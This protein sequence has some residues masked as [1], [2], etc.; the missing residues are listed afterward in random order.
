MS[1]SSLW[2]MNKEYHGFKSKEYRNSWWFSPI[3][4]N[5]LLDKYM[6]DEI[7][8]PYGY[9]KSLIGDFGGQLEGKLNDIINNSENFSDRICWEMSNQQVFFSKDKK[10]I[11]QA[12]IDF[13]NNN[14]N[15]HISK[16]KGISVLR[17]E[18]VVER[19]NKIAHDILDIDENKYPFFVFKNT[20]VDDNVEYWFSKYDERDDK[21]TD[22]SLN[23]LDKYI[24]EFVVIE[25]E[26]IKEFISNLDYFKK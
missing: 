4:W 16:D 5:V 7:Q 26:S 3:V 9:T 1:S 13:N 14:T 17:F 6:H 15:F 19:F 24:T 23:E 18:H 20:S 12:I 8:T 10:V 22:R 21:Y 25:N 11:A 2:V